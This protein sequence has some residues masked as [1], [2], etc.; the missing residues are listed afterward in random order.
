MASLA[1]VNDFV[2]TKNL[3]VVGVSRNGKK[4]GN[5]ILKELKS[6][7][8]NLFPVNPNAD[9][10]E[11]EKCYPNLQSISEEAEGAILVVPP[12]QSEKVVKKAVEVG[13]N[14]IWLQQGA[15]SEKAIQLCKDHNISVVHG[16]CILMFA[17]PVKSFHSFHR[18]I[19][20]LIG[21]LPK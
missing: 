11:G 4:F 18:W 3:A 1:E 13:I 8:Y 5:A 14:K 16:E 15:E 20:K 2:S 9:E 19:W 21:K 6:K 7:G 17:E 12:E 10:I